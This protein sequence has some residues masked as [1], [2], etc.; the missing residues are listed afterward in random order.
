M[1]TAQTTGT[2]PVTSSLVT[3]SSD[4]D[5]N[6]LARIEKAC[7]ELEQKDPN[8]YKQFE[9]SVSRGMDKLRE[10]VPESGNGQVRSKLIEHLTEVL[11][12]HGEHNILAAF[13]ESFDKGMKT[14]GL[15]RY[16]DANNFGFCRRDY[17]PWHLP[18]S[19]KDY[20]AMLWLKAALS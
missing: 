19:K 8:L 1:A 15:K 3:I 9:K 12:S 20:L 6:T 13:F 2:L 11:Q 17:D 4:L 5:E 14:L 16:C 7:V 10:H 18:W